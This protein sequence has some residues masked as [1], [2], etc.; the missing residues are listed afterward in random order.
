[1]SNQEDIDEKL[2]FV[3]IILLFSNLYNYSHEIEKL[4]NVKKST[5]ILSIKV[6]VDHQY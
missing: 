1:M 4:Y 2:I 5:M 6:G 3:V